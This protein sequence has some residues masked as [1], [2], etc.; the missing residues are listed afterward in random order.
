MNE[1][2]IEVKKLS[3]QF[4]TTIALE[5]CDL[6]IKK[7]EIFGFLGPSGAGKT[8]TIKLLTGQLKN[9]SG[10]ILV[11][12]ENPF[13]SKMKQKIGIM[14]DNSG[15]YEKM[16]VYDNLL[17][18][19]KIYDIDKSCI[20][21]VLAEV[22]LLDV[23]NQQVSQLS[24]GMKQ[25]LIFARTIIHSPSLLFLDE[26]TANLDPSTAQEVREIIKKL[27]AKGT[28][29]F[30]TTHN[31]E[32]AD[33]MCHRVAFLNHGHIIESGEPEALKLKYSKQLIR[34]KTDKKDYTIPLD[35]PLLKQELEQM[36]ELLMIHSIEPS[37]KEVFLTLTKEES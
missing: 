24:K 6:M 20:E 14:S 4:A 35:K 26:P 31:M 27:N 23:K 21:K 9:D 37:L 28:T 22:D 16:S 8:T 1:N 32:E 30:L 33:E 34:I 18:F 11:L 13:S 7:G 19:T 17:L 10:D 2:V 12:G 29:V 15:L 25:R 36:N 5:N 3:K